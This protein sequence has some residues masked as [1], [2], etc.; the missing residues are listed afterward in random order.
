ME[1]AITVDGEFKEAA[2]NLAKPI[3]DF[4][5]KDPREGEPASESTEV[6]IL[7]SN[8]SI[9][10]AIH[11]KDAAPSSIRATEL[12]RD[13]E[14]NNDDA[15]SL[16]LD[17]FHDRRNAF[18]FRVNPLG[19]QYDALLTD[20]GRIND[21]NW[22]E[23]WS[24]A[25]RITADGW[26]AEI[27]IPFKSLR[28]SG[29][30]QQ[31][32]GV[33]FERIIRRKNEFTYWS[34]WHRGFTFVQVSRAGTLA[35]LKNLDSGLKLRIKPYVK[36]ELAHISGALPIETDTDSLSDIGLDDLKWR[37]TPDFTADFTVNTDFAETEVDA[38]VLNLTRFPVFFP[39]KREF[40]VEGAG[41]FDYGPGGGAA[42]EMKLFFSRRIGLSPDPERAT[43]PIIAGGKL[44]GKSHGWT[45]GLLDVQTDSFRRTRKR[46]FSV[47]RVKKDVLARSNMG[48]IATNRD[49]T[50]S[51]DPYNRGIGVDANFFFL[52]HLSVQGFLTSTF[53]PG[54]EKDHWAGRWRAYW[55]SDFWFA[56]AERL[57]IQRNFNP[58]M[59]WLPRGDMQKNRFQFDLKPRPGIEGI[60][61][62][63]F[64]STVDYITNQ[65]GDLE[66]RNQDFTFE[67]AFESGDRTMVRYSHLMDRIKRPF[68]IQSVSV[69][70]GDY[71]WDTMLFRFTPA[72]QRRLSG[73]MSLKREWG[74]YGGDNTE[75]NWT[76]VWKATKQLSFSPSYQ[77]N[78]V[79]LPGGKFTSHLINS[80]VNYA[81]NNKWLTS[82]TV[83][84]SNLANLTVVNFRLDYIYR[85]GDDLFLIYNR[86]QVLESDST[87][88]QTN[89]AI[90]AKLTHSFD[91]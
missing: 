22:D 85:A 40:F 77:F 82:G 23:K 33:D 7:Y 55:D 3:T 78:R 69:P 87:T 39:E 57:T 91:F 24:S 43:I 11:C 49:S 53:S 52:D 86:S 67:T 13:N 65:T 62:V 90:I 28:T 89:Q 80:Q 83:Q 19:T 47:L 41:I 84:Y 10:F 38:Q 68:R 71:A 30:E 42:S 5:Q 45:M 36:T 58:E 1:E 20:E 15:F 32:W 79:K 76:P 31:V 46:N 34:N 12:R 56:N 25:A 73:D 14:F 88:R 16:V 29:A 61:Q 50:A 72:T 54:K 17:T 48:F 2:W 27:E 37:V 74:F 70:L 60:R 66:T 59:G 18:L 9:Y 6:R 64:R 35:G 75:I 63:F 51:G 26:V 81:F 44:T 21:V 8:R 4:L